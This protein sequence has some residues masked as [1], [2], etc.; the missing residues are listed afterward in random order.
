MLKKKE[1][2]IKKK[3]VQFFL[4]NHNAEGDLW[5]WGG[6]PIY[7]NG[8]YCGT[9]TSTAYSYAL[10]KHVCLGYVKNTD[11]ETREKGCIDDELFM[12]DAEFEV[13]IAGKYFSAKANII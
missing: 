8:Q 13:N 10:N 4:Q 2:G 5:P 7:R 6:E 12:K 3:L 9:T 1:E 11:P